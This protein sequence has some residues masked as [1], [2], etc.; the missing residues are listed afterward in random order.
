MTLI[1]M[2]SVN[3]VKDG[4]T[5][6]MTSDTR[7]MQVKLHHFHALS[8]GAGCNLV[9]ICV[10]FPSCRGTSSSVSMLSITTAIMFE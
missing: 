10:M 3:S 1:V 2:L 6:I 4:V 5:N 7:R 9:C 8:R